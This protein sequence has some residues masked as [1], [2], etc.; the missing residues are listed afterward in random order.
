MKEMTSANHDRRC[1][2]IRR[3]GGEMPASMSD[4][5]VTPEVIIIDRRLAG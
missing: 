2:D 5:H 4:H 1:P 3:A